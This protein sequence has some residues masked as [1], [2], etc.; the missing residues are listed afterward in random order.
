MSVQRA[1]K[2]DLNIVYD[3]DLHRRFVLW[4]EQSG[5]SLNGIAQK[6]DR[7]T[8]AISQ[9]INMK[10]MGD[11]AELEK[12][13]AN[14]LRREEDLQFVTGAREFCNTTP[15]KLIW[16]VLQYCDAKKKMGVALAPSGT[17]KTETCKEYKRQNRATIFVTAD[18]TTRA[19]AAILRRIVQQ[20][21]GT[22]RR[23]STSEFLHAMIDR[24]KG[25]QRL[26][27]I[28]DAHFLKWESFELVRKVYD[29]AGIGVVYVGQER[30]YEQMKGTDRNSYLFDQ[31]YSRIAIRR[32]NFLIYKN[33]V[34]AVVSIMCKGLDKECIDYLYQKA[35]GKGRFRLVENIIDVAMEMNKQYQ[36][37]IN[38][39]LLQEADRFLIQG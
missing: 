20:T 8:A 1:V 36:K 18:I 21:G 6:I 26:L 17:G 14:L 29:C 35:K 31:I 25:S 28:D 16:E 33:D 15:A 23:Y 13:I 4:K 10:Y 38:M 5:T 2:E 24:L 9:Y 32:D 22:G 27:I 19:P 34:K 7:S 30:L 12:D 39:Q 3:E 11:I 37:P